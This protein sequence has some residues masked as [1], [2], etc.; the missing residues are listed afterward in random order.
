MPGDSLGGARGGTA[1]L[2]V[3]KALRA[4]CSASEPLGCAGAGG[5]GGR[6]GGFDTLIGGGGGA[7][8]VGGGGAG[9]GGGGAKDGGGGAEDGG[10]G[11]EDGGGGGGAPG[12]CKRDAA[13]GLREAGGGKGGFLPTG[14]GGL[15]FPN[16]ASE[17]LEPR[18]GR[19]KF[20]CAATPDR[21]GGL[22]AAP[23]GAGGAG[24]GYLRAGD[25][26]SGSESYKLTPPVLLRNCGMPPA[27]RPPSCGAAAMGPA[28]LLFVPWSLWLRA[29]LWPGGLRLATAPGPGIGTGGAPE[30]G[31]AAEREDNLA[32][33][34]GAERS[35][36]WVT[37]FRRAPFSMSPRRAPCDAG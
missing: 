8:D 31:G 32:S 28:P 19:G 3:R 33:T 2:V 30:G 25:D 16:G 4:A 26:V 6:D 10:G 34:M 23:L 11:A 22:G 21:T 36:T 1:G 14:G 29:R 9:D 27:N 15:G 17:T 18:P 35:L 13:E 12:E 37:F 7:E 5:A 24:A 20:L